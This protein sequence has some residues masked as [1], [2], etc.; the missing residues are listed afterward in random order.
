MLAGLYYEMP[1]PPVSAYEAKPPVAAAVTPYNLQN[2]LTRYPAASQ[3]TCPNGGVVSPA[4]KSTYVLVTL[5]CRI[6]I[7]ICC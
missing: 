5:E 2:Q 4:A 1:C 7:E 3:N 6:R